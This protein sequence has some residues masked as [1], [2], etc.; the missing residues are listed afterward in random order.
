MAQHGKAIITEDA[1]DHMLDT[2]AFEAM[3]EAPEAQCDRLATTN[4]HSRGLD[5]F[6]S[7]MA[8]S[9]GSVLPGELTDDLHPLLQKILS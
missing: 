9:K 6:M 8:S 7:A 5:L 4:D 2:I 3:R 1:A